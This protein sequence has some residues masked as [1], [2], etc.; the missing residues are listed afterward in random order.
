MKKLLALLLAL[1]MV[2]SLVACAGGNDTPTTTEPKTDNTTAAKPDNTTAAPTTEANLGWQGQLPISTTNEK[3]VVGMPSRLNTMDYDTNKFTLWLEEQTGIDLVFKYYSEV[4]SELRNQVAL[5]VGANE[6]LP[7]IFWG[8]P[9]SRANWYEYG[10]DG[11]LMDLSELW[12]QYNYN[13]EQG[14]AKLPDGMREAMIAYATDPVDNGLYTIPSV[15]YG[16]SSDS[17]AH[18]VTINKVWLDKIG[19]DVPTTV[20]E[21][22]EVLKLFKTTDCNGNGK[23]DEIPCIWYAGWLAHLPQWVINA[24]IYCNDT[25]VYNINDG[26]V[27]VPYDQPE[28][29]EALK[30]LNKWYEEGL[31]SDQSFAIGKSD[32]ATMKS[33]YNPADELP[34]LGLVGGHPVVI[35][36]ADSNITDDYV[37]CGP[38][39]DETGKGGYA[40]IVAQSVELYCGVSATCA[41]PELAL[42]FIDFMWTEEALARQNYGEEGV[43]WKWAKEGQLNLNGEQATIEVI[44]SRLYGTQNNV[45]WNSG[46][47]VG[48]DAGFSTVYTDDGSWNSIQ[49]QLTKSLYMQYYNGKQPAQT[50]PKWVR[51]AEETE[52]YNEYKGFT[53]YMA[54]AR[55]LFIIGELDIDD[56]K[57]WK[58]YLDTLELNG[59]SKIIAA[60]QSCWDRMFG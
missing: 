27:S 11:Y 41:N 52:I 50:A 45:L 34:I 38:L 51:N 30:T 43:H 29:R 18:C 2:M 39:K 53:N 44:G 56:D 3:L 60:H 59:M 16:K 20:D 31:I 23:Q 14:V 9:L 28:Y 21:V 47:G 1:C 35:S 24:Y 4:Q 25:D 54:D 42:K 26:V 32:H 46:W 33:M 22:Y 13:W 48:L 55:N 36:V 40:P 58:E 57:V 7:D 37:G 10:E 15:Q 6:K 8:M 19:K 5:E 12:P 49:S 17:L